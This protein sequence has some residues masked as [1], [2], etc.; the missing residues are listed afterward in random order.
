MIS[1][2]AEFP[3]QELE[4]LPTAVAV[5]HEHEESDVDSVS[6]GSSFNEDELLQELEGDVINGSSDG[7]KVRN[8]ISCI[9]ANTSISCR[10]NQFE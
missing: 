3:I 8:L 1:W 6:D 10:R 2:H 4:A 5:E 9:L 7:Y